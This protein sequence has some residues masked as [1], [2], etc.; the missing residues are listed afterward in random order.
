MQ[1]IKTSYTYSSIWK[2][3]YPIFLTLLVQN[4]IQV[5][6]TAFLGRVGEVELGASALAGIYYIVIFMLAFGFSTGSQILIGR[7][8]GEQNYHKIGEIV[9]GGICFLLLM[10]LGL[11]FI[12]SAFSE[13]ILSKLL[14]SQNILHAAVEYLDLRIYGIFFASINVMFRAFYVGTTR[15]KVLSLNALIMALT[16]IFF[17]YV[18]IFGNWGFP[19]MGIAGAALSAVFSEIVSVVFFLVYTSTQVDLEKYGFKAFT[20]KK[21]LVVRKILNISLSLMLQNFLSLGSWFFF[22]LAI[23]HLG[24]QPLA[25]SNIV[26]SLYMLISIPVFAL[27]ATA[28]TLVSN[29]IGAGRKDE[30]MSLVWKVSKFAIMI[31]GVFM[32]FSFLFPRLE[33]SIYTADKE[34]IEAAIPSLYMVLMVLPLIAMSNVFFSSIS[35]TGNTRTALALEICVLVF[36]IFY[37]WFTIMHLKLPLFLSWTCEYVYGFFIFLFSFIYMKKGGWRNKVI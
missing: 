14:N 2:I 15:T 30:V 11:F 10:A 35:G 19:Q 9:V 3:A 7:R 23:E 12:T 5:I 37:I 26:R 18:L 8:N 28:N 21:L 20:L 36:Y 24:E 31:C 13:T 6:G 32:L 22:F 25:I 16:T 27:A 34:L 33:L 1:Q 17:D 29:T 4:L